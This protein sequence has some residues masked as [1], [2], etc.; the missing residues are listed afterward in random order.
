MQIDKELA[1]KYVIELNKSLAMEHSA[2]IQYGSHA[3]Q[4]SG[5][6]SEPLIARIKDTQHD[7]E[8]HADKLRHLIGD[9]LY[10]IPTQAVS[11]GKSASDNIK[12]ILSVNIATEQEA[13][14]QYEKILGM[15]AQDKD[16]LKA[17]YYVLEHEIRHILMEESEHIAEL[18]RLI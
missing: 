9:Y 6:M 1:R 8:K 4:I 3:E 7:E 2:S 18:E 13:I 17:V 5:P 16:A 14:I 11:A 10:G 15:L 12:D